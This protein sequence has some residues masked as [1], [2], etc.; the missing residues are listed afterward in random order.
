MKRLAYFLTIVI[1]ANIFFSSCQRKAITQE[2]IDEFS[3][4]INTEL[5]QLNKHVED[6][7][8]VA[9]SDS[10]SSDSAV[11]ITPNESAK[12]A[13]I[14]IHQSNN[15][16]G[17]W[18]VLIVLIAVIIPF[19]SLV[20]IIFFALRAITSRQRE[21]NK[22]VEI[23]IKSNYPLPDNFFSKPQTSRT[24]LQSA[25]VWLACGIGSIVFFL[26]VFDD[27]LYAIG[28]IPLLIGIAKLIT[29]YVEDRKN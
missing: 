27:A 11:I 29:Y 6:S 21:H 13:N 26:V 2:E 1:T 10:S 14:S 17:F 19:A 22:L 8:S 24:R 16:A 20:L 7:I 12:I 9:I 18:V 15:D 3:K 4:K 23:A 28:I 5:V 25:L